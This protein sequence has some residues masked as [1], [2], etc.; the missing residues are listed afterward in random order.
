MK[1]FY[2]FHS[3]F[4]IEIEN[5]KFIFD[6]YSKYKKNNRKFK[7]EDFII[8]NKNILV[9]S[10]HNHSDHFDEKILQWKDVNPNIKYIL[11]DDIKIN[12]KDF[13]CHFV[14]EGDI[15]KIDDI[16]I[17]V[18][19]STDLGVSFFVKYKDKTFFHS[20]DLNWWYWSDDTKEEEEYM[21]NLYFDKIQAIENSLKAE[22]ID[23]LF[24][25][26]D[27][28]LEEYGFLGVEYFIEK[29]KVKN[30]IPIHMFRKYNFVDKLEPKL[31]NISIIKTKEENSL[32]LETEN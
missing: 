7:I 13:N 9:F 18:F 16:E 20:G 4:A 14:K 10:S 29:L 25:P 6:Y 26:V 5:Y 2:I 23:Y 15:L 31:K 8:D 21:R 12:S 30:L 17:K 19:G 32:I 27:P 28:R 1:I 11:S 24:Y 22:T 3:G